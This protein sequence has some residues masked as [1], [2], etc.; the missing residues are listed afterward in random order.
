MYLCEWSER[1]L[2]HFN[3]AKLKKKFFFATEPENNLA[4][5]PYLFNKVLANSS[6]PILFLIAVKNF[7]SFDYENLQP[8]FLQHQKFLLGLC[9]IGKGPRDLSYLF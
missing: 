3:I 8:W 2:F 5:D 1:A 6:I 9:Q 7:V 4:S